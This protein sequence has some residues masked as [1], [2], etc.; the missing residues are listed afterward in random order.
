MAFGP[1]RDDFRML[2]VFDALARLLNERSSDGSLAQTSCGSVLSSSGRLGTGISRSDG[3][4][5]GVECQAV[6]KIKDHQ[7]YDIV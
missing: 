4:G 1:T 5:D 3:D 2:F 7:A 6:Q